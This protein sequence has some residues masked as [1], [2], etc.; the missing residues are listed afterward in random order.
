VHQCDC[1]PVGARA[2]SSPSCSINSSVAAVTWC[3]P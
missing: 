3:C 2:P 1:A